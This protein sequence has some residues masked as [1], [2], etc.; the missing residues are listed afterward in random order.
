MPRIPFNFALLLPSIL[1]LIIIILRDDIMQW[2]Y[3][4]SYNIAIIS[5]GETRNKNALSQMVKLWRLISVM[6]LGRWNCNGNVKHFSIL[7]F[8]SIIAMKWV[9]F[10]FRF[11][12]ENFNVKFFKNETHSNLI[13]KYILKILTFLAKNYSRSIS[14]APN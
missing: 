14:N 3:I 5:L 7:I 6:W 8:I 11:F 12:M 10:N 4:V 13:F 1:S 2:L 9:T